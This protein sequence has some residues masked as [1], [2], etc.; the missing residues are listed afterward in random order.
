MTIA[1]G[2]VINGASVR[3]TVTDYDIWPP[4]GTIT[5]NVGWPSFG[6]VTPTTITFIETADH[7]RLAQDLEEAAR[8]FE[9]AAKAMEEAFGPQSQPA[10]QFKRAMREAKKAVEQ[11][12][13]EAD[14][15]AGRL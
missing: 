12:R 1:N 10:I 11:A 13:F 8:D 7:A 3:D 5:M 9:E 14:K 2:R 15:A 6:N 4:T